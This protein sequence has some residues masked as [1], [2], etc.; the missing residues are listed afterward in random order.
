MT[1]YPLN[2]SAL[3]ISPFESDHCVLRQVFSHSNWQL[4]VAVDCQQALDQIREEMVPVVICS[5]DSH[6]D[7]WKKIVQE[8]ASWPHPPRVVV[9]S[10]LA[11][12]RLWADVIHH[13]GYTLLDSPFDMRDIVTNVSLAWHSWY[14]EYRQNA[15]QLQRPAA[16]ARIMNAMAEPAIA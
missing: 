10:R 1:S 6:P 13:G 11:D 8:T 14:H 9:F 2:I 3:L 16:T 5:A 12:E 4:R 15:A 7:W